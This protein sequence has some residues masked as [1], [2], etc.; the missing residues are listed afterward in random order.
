[1]C[2]R[3]RRGLGVRLTTGGA[4][5]CCGSAGA[6]SLLFPETAAL[7]REARLDGLLASGAACIASANVGCIA[8]LQAGTEL[9]VLHWL[10]LLEP[11][12]GSRNPATA[13][14]TAG[15]PS[16]RRPGGRRC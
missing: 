10:E 16:Y 8:H 1:M 12:P 14:A 7:L 5:P 9:P 2:I 11:L 15:R 13:C 3:D 4:G 6:Y